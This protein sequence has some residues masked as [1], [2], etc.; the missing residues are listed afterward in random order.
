MDKQNK[1]LL[2][3]VIVVVVLAT[4]GYAYVSYL[5]SKPLTYEDKIDL[6]DNLQ[7]KTSTSTSEEKIQFVEE[8]SDKYKTETQ[9][10]DQEKMNILNSLMNNSEGNN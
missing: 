5:N 2:Y 8:F 1:I 9:I 7:D 3:G 6:L 10:S 4:A